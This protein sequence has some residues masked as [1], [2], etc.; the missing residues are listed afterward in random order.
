MATTVL[1]ASGAAEV[2]LLDRYVGR[3]F[4][5]LFCLILVVLV[6]VSIV[7]NVFENI[8][9]IV[10]AQATLA[11]IAR[12]YLFSVP[13]YTMRVAAMAVLL[14]SLLSLGRLAR[15]HELLG[16]QM[17]GVSPPRVVRPILGLST[18]IC[19]GLL[20]F[21]ETIA[22]A[23]NE[24]MLKFKALRLY[25]AKV[26]HQTKESDIWYMLGPQEMLHIALLQS[27]E[28][29]MRDM[30]LYQFNQEFQLVRRIDAAR[31]RWQE[32][33]WHMEGVSVRTFENGGI[34]RVTSAPTMRLD[35]RATPSDLAQVERDVREMSFQELRQYIRRLTK[36]GLDARR[37]W[38][39]LYAKLSTPFI[40]LVMSCIGIGFALRAGR[41]GIL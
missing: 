4:C 31:A 28:G 37:Y 29:L 22:P 15:H 3:E 1:P 8:N 20:A 39:D 34:S 26:F 40:S 2:R 36:S 41:Q 17:G 14:A 10:T 16:M 5:A 30:T 25:G 9:R 33:Q 27:Q 18:L 38:V 13:K 21:G 11:E 23:A 12:Y 19:L 35:V 7:I 6:A 32:G 24:E